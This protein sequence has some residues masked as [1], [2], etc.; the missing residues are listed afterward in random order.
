MKHMKHCASIAVGAMI[1]G[2]VLAAPTPE[3]VKQLGTTLTPVG[4]VRAGNAAGTIPE[5]KG[6]LCKPVP[7]YQPKNGKQGAPYVDPFAGEKPLFHIT[8]AN[9]AEHADKLDEGTKELM[10]RYPT[11]GI[12]VYPTHRTACH[13]DWVYKNTIEGVM[14]PSLIGDAPG[15]TGAHAQ[16]PFP[17]PKSGAE[18][19]W[20]NILKWEPTA[21][22]YDFEAGLMDAAGNFS[23]ASFQWAITTNW[24]W[25]NSL[26]SLPEDRPYRALVAK[27][28]EPASQVGTQNLRVTYLR[29]DLHPDMAWSYSPGQRRVRRSPEFKFDTVSTTSGGLLIFDEI[30]A[31]DGTLEKYN[32]NIV[33]RKEM[34]IPYNNW[35]MIGAPLRE[36]MPKD[37]ANVDLLRWELHRVWVV[38]GTLKDGQRHVQQKKVFLLDEDS[39]LSGV[40][41]GVDHSGKVHHLM[42]LPLVQQYDKPGPRSGPMVLYDLSRG[43]YGFQNKPEGRPDQLGYQHVDPKPRAF[44]APDALAGRGVR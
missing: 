11:F 16:I 8:A 28:L 38:E 32:W 6:G 30:N 23:S 14:N 2:Q 43:I 44:F 21:Y 5:W 33:G 15:I 24:Y 17:I 39:W 29:H 7:G 19:M 36:T 27:V 9:M 1:A 35:Q 22:E 20:N 10:R 42:H 25:D 34:Y 40:Y 4:A 13:E 26:T 37:H 18:A 41:Y 12:K 3:E 31:F